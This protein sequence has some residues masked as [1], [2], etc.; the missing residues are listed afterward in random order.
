MDNTIILARVCGIMCLVVGLTA[1]NKSFIT[2]VINELE[3]SKAMF[4]FAGF[5]AALL[6]A[7][8]LALYSAWSPHWRVLITILGWLSLL[9]GV[10]IMLAPASLMSF[11]RKFKTSGIIVFSGIIGLLVGI[12][13]LYKGFMA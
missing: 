9:K 13:L 4:W 7:I 3:N 5:V 1:I 10:V 6:G 8:V 11:Y 2:S 12:I